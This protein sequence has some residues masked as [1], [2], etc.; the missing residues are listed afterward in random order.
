M[1]RIF[2][3]TCGLVAFANRDDQ[4]HGDAKRAWNELVASPEIFLTTSLVLV[5]IGD[6]LSRVDFRPLA[7]QI[8]D[9]LRGSERVEIIQSDKSL[10]ERTWALFRDR[11]D[12]DWGMTDCVSMTVMRD[13]QIDEV[14]TSDHHFEQAGYRI[15]IRP[16][17]G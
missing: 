7:L 4:W 5:E 6:G 2:L 11:S 8:C 15:L 3:D 1:K 16:N 14:F 12:K 9:G 17:R 13:W 10:E